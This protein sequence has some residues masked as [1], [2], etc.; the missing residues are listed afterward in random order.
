MASKTE[1]MRVTISGR[2]SAGEF[3][4]ALR[5]I[6]DLYNLR[7]SLELAYGR[8]YRRPGGSYWSSSDTA[9]QT[10]FWLG[11]YLFEDPSE[12]LTV[13]RVQYGSPG[14]ADLAG[15]GT[16]V[17]HIKDFITDLINRQDSRRHR[18]L[19][20]ERAALENDRLRIQNAADFVA[21]AKEL[22]FTP[23]DLRRMTL[24]VDERQEVLKRLI[25]EKKLR[26]VTMLDDGQE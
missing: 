23:L 1:I 13:V 5:S 19:E 7:L 6:S 15:I 4:D 20:D 3:A 22:G 9:D 8:R 16:I 10:N 2:W 14:I 25:D 18:E 26:D 12:R 17:G 24:Q 11:G 21:L